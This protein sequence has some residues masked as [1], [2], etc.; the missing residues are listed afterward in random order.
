MKKT[1]IIG[2]LAASVSLVGCSQPA[3]PTASG[4]PST[5]ATTAASTPESTKTPTATESPQA[6]GGLPYEFPAHQP[7]VEKGQFAFVPMA[8]SIEKLGGGG[9]KKVSDFRPREVVKVGEETTTIMDRKEFEAPNSLVVPIPK[10]ATASNGDI[11]VGSP[12]YGSWEVAIVT[13]ASNPSKPIVHM[14]KPVYSGEPEGDKF[15]SQYE[16]GKFRVVQSELDPG[17][18][19]L[20]PDGDEKGYGL[21]IKSEADSVLVET[22][23]GDLAVFQKDE[24]TPIP[25][26]PGVKKDDK[27]QAPFAKGMDPAT[28]TKV[29]EKTGRVWVTFDGREG[30]G[31]KCFCFGQVLPG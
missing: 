28:V 17:S 9:K 2:L 12:Q 15:L 5:Q 10:D 3:P 31:E 22:F 29:D 19:A 13:D 7:Q 30:Q 4:T 21:V 24:V 6:A 1:L 18:H 20:Y 11:V 26:K 14:F 25:V 27:V 23:G 8:S 16:S